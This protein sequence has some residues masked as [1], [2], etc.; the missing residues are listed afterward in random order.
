MK[1]AIHPQFNK[2]EKGE[3]GIRRVWEMQQKYLPQHGIEIVTKPSEADLV[4]IHADELKTDRPFVLHCHGLYYAGYEWPLW[5]YDANEKIIRGMKKAVAV[6]APSQFV[7]HYLAR[8]MLL[9]STVLMHGVEIEQWEPTENQG[10]VIWSKNRPDA[11]CNPQDVNR[12]AELAPDTF[13]MST[14]G[15]T[16]LPNLKTIGRVPYDTIREFTRH[17]GVYLATTLETGGIALMEAMAAGVPALG[18]AHGANTEIIVHEETGYLAAPGDFVDLR[19]GL[20]YCLDNRRR[21]GNNA[22]SHIHHNYQW[23]DRIANYVPFYQGALE[24]YDAL[25]TGPRTSIIVTAYQLADYLPA[26]IESVLAQSDPDWELII[27]DDASP[28]E[29]GRIADE[30]AQRDSRI[31]VLHNPTNLY[32]AEARNSGIRSARGE[33]ILP[34]DADDKLSPHAVE[35]LSDALDKDSNL[36]IV[37]GS[38]ELVEPDG[39]HWISSWPSDKPSFNQQIKQHNQVPYASMYRKWVWER[40]GGYRRRMHTAEDAEFWSRAMSYGAVPAKVTNA[41][42]LVYANRP[43]SMSHSIPTPAWT[44]WF[45][46]GRHSPLFTPF[47]ASGEPPNKKAWPVLPYG[48]PLVSIVIPC[49]PGHEFYLQDSIDSCVAQTMQNLEVI[50][51]N[52]TGTKWFSE[53]G[54]LLCP[55]ILGYPFVRFLDSEGPAKGPAHARNR[56]IAASSAP[57]FIL[58]DADDFAQ[59]LAADSLYA[60]WQ[61]R[62][63]WIYSDFWDQDGNYKESQ[64]FSCEDAI[65]KMPGPVTGIYSKEDWVL[66][67][68][69]DEDAPGWEDYSYI[70]SLMEQ[71]ICGTRLKS[72]T[73][74][75]RY[76]AGNRRETDYADSAT[77]LKWIRKKHRQLYEK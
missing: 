69:F 46:W 17:A 52:D 15:N 8:G 32:L 59:P 73:F 40:T 68:G 71:G 65:I 49:G 28:D 39:K 51:V 38:M 55:Y 14:F 24:N 19:L 74:T 26:C 16:D 45:P 36:D 29:C 43:Q 63:G 66:V 4:A 34:L 70:L 3:G 60:V 10:Y 42:T 13:F 56:G 9:D 11:I 30:Y 58:L 67:G 5:A 64:D 75:Y 7:R 57:L 50:V 33:F 54:E 1:L 27:V 18:F 22:R 21:L 72:A 41:V 44:D 53:S 61:D 23:K 37:C 20:A 31:K 35:I 25:H 77:I 2:I 76:N 62:K 47:G 6:S 12:L 48:P